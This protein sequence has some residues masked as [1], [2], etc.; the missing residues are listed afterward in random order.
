MLTGVFQLDSLD[1]ETLGILS[2]ILSERNSLAPI[3]RLPLDVLT[4]IP[5]FWDR[6]ERGK[7]IIAVTHVCRAWRE[8]FISR[9]S[10]WT[11]FHCVDEDKTRVYLERSKSA[12]IDVW[13]TGRLG[14]SPNDPFLD[15]VPRAIRRLKCLS[16][17]IMPDRFQDIIQH[18][19][20]PAPFLEALEIGCGYVRPNPVLPTELFDGDLSSLRKLRI[21]SVWTQLPWRNMGKLTSLSLA[22]FSGPAIFVGQILE[23]FQSAPLLREVSLFFVVPMSGACGG[24]LV[25]LSHLRKL[26]ICESQPPHFLLNHLIIPV[27]ANLFTE[28]DSPGPKIDDH[29]PKS[30]DNLRNFSHF[31]KIRLRYDLLSHVSMQFTGP[32]GQVCIASSFPSPDATEAV[33]RSLARFDTSKTRCL[34]I[35][36]SGFTTGLYE[37]LASLTNLH[38]LIISRCVDQPAFLVG[39][40]NTLFPNGSVVCPKLEEL[41]IRTSEPSTVRYMAETA[42]LRASKGSPLKL[43][44]V[45]SFGEPVSTEWVAGLQRHVSCVETSVE[46]DDG[47]RNALDRHEDEDL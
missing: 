47:D 5:D 35:V 28:F 36:N 9:A 11:E 4:L 24:G 32:N 39:L 8:M 46:V 6:P 41:V 43:V 37:A 27:G 31:T 13:L 26:S 30:F 1:Q 29:L 17:A 10:L 12:L 7:A 42:E 34:E 33:P 44:K 16:L 14:S 40:K 45:V 25:T 20:H 21:S 19:A 38:A 2:L 15:V 3:D 23:F 18:L 22:F